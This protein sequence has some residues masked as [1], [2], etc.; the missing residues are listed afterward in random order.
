VHVVSKTVQQSFGI[1]TDLPWEDFL[2]R[3]RARFDDP[4]AKLA[5]KLSGDPVRAPPF[6]LHDDCDYK[7][8]ITR[9]VAL[10]TRARTKKIEMSVYNQVCI[11]SFCV[12]R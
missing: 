6:Q 4:A 5:Y 8:A 2:S 3:T 7:E 10:C 11:V 1:Q 12:P 9:V